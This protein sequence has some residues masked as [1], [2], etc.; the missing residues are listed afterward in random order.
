M[1]TADPLTVPVVVV[2]LTAQTVQ[3]DRLAEWLRAQAA[4]PRAGTA[5]WALLLST[6]RSALLKNAGR[7]LPLLLAAF[8][9]VLYFL[10]P[11]PLL[12]QPVT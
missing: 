2:V 5:S 8:Y 1:R 3:R 11:F 9:E 7:C 10:K 12:T 4:G 6:A